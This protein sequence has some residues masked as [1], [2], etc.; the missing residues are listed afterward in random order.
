MR[1]RRL[2]VAVAMLA[3]ACGGAERATAPGL[4][5]GGEFTVSVTRDS[6]PK[7]SWTAGN[8]WNVTVAAADLSYPPL[9]QVL[10]STRQQRGI[11]SPVTFGSIPAGAFSVDTAA[12]LVRGTRYVAIVLLPDARSAYAEFV[13]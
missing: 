6:T 8:A 11:A 9:W 10:D 12:T 1:A 13:Y 5:A 2:A 3:A 4:R 7:I